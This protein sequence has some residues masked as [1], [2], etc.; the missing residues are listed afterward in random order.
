MGIATGDAQASKI[1]TVRMADKDGLLKSSW[2]AVKK[3][4]GIHSPTEIFRADVRFEL[5]DDF[6]DL[7]YDFVQVDT[8]ARGQSQTSLVDDYDA[9]SEAT[10]DGK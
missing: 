10:K 9:Y 5:P 3:F 7:P 2:S 8:S 4:L 6:F 1:M